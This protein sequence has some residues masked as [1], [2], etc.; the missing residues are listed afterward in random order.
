MFDR[1]VAISTPEQVEVYD[2]MIESRPEFAFYSGMLTQL[3]GDA[4]AAK[5]S[6][7]MAFEQ[8]FKKNS[9]AWL[10]ALA[11]VEISATASMYG[12]SKTPFLDLVRNSNF[13]IEEYLSVL[14]DDLNA[15]INALATDPDL[16]AVCKV[17]VKADSNTLAYLRRIKLVKDMLAAIQTAANDRY[18]YQ[19]RRVGKELEKYEKDLVRKVL[20]ST[21]NLSRT[22]V[23]VRSSSGNRRRSSSALGNAQSCQQLAERIVSDQ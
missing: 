5:Q 20:L 16:K 4:I 13:G 10:L 3:G 23:N 18:A 2:K 1:L 12:R 22:D 19:A 7:P 21:Q 15:H 6:K 11:R 17:N 8:S 14:A 9:L